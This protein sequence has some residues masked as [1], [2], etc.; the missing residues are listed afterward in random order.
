MVWAWSLKQ[1]L[2]VVRS[3]LCGLPTT[4]MVY[5]SHERALALLF[6]L[7]LGGTIGGAFAGVLIPLH[8][9]LKAVE[10]RSN[11]FFARGMVGSDVKEF[12]SGSQALGS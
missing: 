8:L 1:F 5:G 9:A 2:E 6:F 4:P 12:L 11:R 7:F 10:D 3:A